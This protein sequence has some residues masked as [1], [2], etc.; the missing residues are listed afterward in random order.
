MIVTLALLL[1]ALG[2][3]S[4]SAVLVAVFVS[5]PDWVTVAVSVS[6]ADPPFATA[7]MS[8]MPVPLT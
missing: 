8:Q 7:P 1:A 6:V 4:F 5:G 3:V 2:S